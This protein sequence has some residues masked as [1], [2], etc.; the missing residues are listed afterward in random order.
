SGARPATETTSQPRSMSANA[1]VVPARPGPTS[2]RGWFPADSVA[3]TN[4]PLR[5]PGAS[6]A[7][8]RLQGYPCVAHAFPP[9]IRVDEVGRDVTE[10]RQHESALPHARA[11]NAETPLS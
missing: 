3:S 10:R 4:A 5:G 7:R 2:A 6:N 8:W 1:S 11:R 9:R